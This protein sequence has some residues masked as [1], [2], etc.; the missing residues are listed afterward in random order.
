MARN[1]YMEDLNEEEKALFCYAS[2]ENLF[3]SASAAQKDHE[4]KSKSWAIFG[5]L[6]P[7]ISA[8]DQYSSALDVY[9]NTY[10]LAMAPLSGSI[11]V[12]L[13]VCLPF[14]SHSCRSWFLI[15]CHTYTVILRLQSLLESTSKSSSICSRELEMSF[16]DV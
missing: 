12:L 2:L 9:S 16:Q 14:M 10:S 8:V 4:E 1:R 5:R 3:Y 13:H 11:R 7:L 6:E 15:S